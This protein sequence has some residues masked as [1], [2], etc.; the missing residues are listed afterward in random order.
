MTEPNFYREPV[1]PEG[2]MPPC[3]LVRKLYAEYLR[4]SHHHRETAGLLTL[5]EIVATASGKFPNG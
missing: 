4:V 1:V 5:A 2:Y 3:E